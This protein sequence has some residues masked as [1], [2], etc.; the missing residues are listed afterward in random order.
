MASND[1]PSCQA[2]DCKVCC[3]S[4]SFSAPFEWKPTDDV[5]FVA[6]RGVRGIEV[7]SL[8]ALPEILKSKYGNAI[9]GQKPMKI[10]DEPH[11]PHA[12]DILQPALFLNLFLTWAVYWYHNILTSHVGHPCI[13]RS[14]GKVVR[15]QMPLTKRLKLWI[16]FS[17]LFEW[18]DRLHIFRWY[19]HREA[20]ISGAYETSSES[21]KDIPIFIRQYGIDMSAFEPSDPN[22]Y[23]CFNDFFTRAHKEGSRPLAEPG[24]DSVTV[25]AADSRLVVFDTV[26]LTKAFWIK[27]RHFSITTLMGGD[28]IAEKKAQKWN[29][30]SVSVYRLSPQDYHRYHSPVA[31]RVTWIRHIP[32]NYYGVDPMA[33]QS[34]VPVLST[35]ARTAI[36]ISTPKYGDVLF[37]AI[38]AEEVGSVKIV[39][40]EG[41]ELKRGDEVGQFAFGGSS[42]M[43]CYERGRV[44]WDEDVREASLLGFMMDIKVRERIGKLIVGAE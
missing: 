15:E 33:V 9:G 2:H 30:G 12:R 44:D 29:E 16:L 10:H 20:D 39:L 34:D 24:D 27:G 17:P 40:K 32:G 38:G 31:G 41:Q 4:S 43:V 35:N 25:S 6:V 28:D 5:I 19:L 7:T 3:P 22:E 8:C 21:R 42:I 18:I 13:I 1:G 23:R 14:T 26:N 36:I 37:V 11:L